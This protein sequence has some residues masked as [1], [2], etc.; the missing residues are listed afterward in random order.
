MA[1]SSEADTG[2]EVT[3]LAEDPAASAAPA[4]EGWAVPDLPLDPVT[5]PHSMSSGYLS[6]HSHSPPDTGPEMEIFKPEVDLYTPETEVE[7]KQVAA[8]LAGRARAGSITD[9]EEESR[10]S[11]V[12]ILRP[13]DIA[14]LSLDTQYLT[15]PPAQSVTQL[16]P[17][18]QP[19][20]LVQPSSAPPTTLPETQFF[21]PPARGLTAPAAPPRV[22]PKPSRVN[23]VQTRRTGAATLP[24][25]QFVRTDKQDAGTEAK[26]TKE[27][28]KK[29]DIAT[30]K[31]KKPLKF[32]KLWR[33][34]G[35][36]G[37]AGAGRVP[38]D[39]PHRSLFTRTLQSLQLRKVVVEPAV[40]PVARPRLATPPR[41]ASSLPSRLGHS[42]VLLSPNDTELGGG[43][44]GRGGEGGRAGSR[45]DGPILHTARARFQQQDRSQARSLHRST[46]N[47]TASNKVTLV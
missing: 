1:G 38:A 25:P 35:G 44:G 21:I 41:P 39:E 43:A 30:A 17:H 18:T 7:A 33:R 24:R 34:T 19:A 23:F 32:S 12:G 26:E 42:I 5:P 28:G 22:A 37:R 16:S 6:A 2:D 4:E 31:E 10:L 20:T 36:G 46:L 15:H 27:G 45:V 3:E 11:S 8:Q 9:T 14:A 13:A 47:L 29:D 40:E